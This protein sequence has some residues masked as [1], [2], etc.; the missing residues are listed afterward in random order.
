M[1]NSPQRRA[2]PVVRA[3]EPRSDAKTAPSDWSKK[4]ADAGGIPRSLRSGRRPPSSCP[5]DGMR[6]RDGRWRSPTGKTTDVEKVRVV[7]DWILCQH[8]P[9]SQGFEAAESG[10]IRDHARD[11]EISRRG[12]CGDI[13]AALRG[14]WCVR[15]ACQRATSYGIRVGPSAFRLQGPRSGQ[16]PTSARPSTAAPRSSCPTT[17][18]PRWT[19]PMSPRWRARGDE[20]VAEVEQPAGG[21]GAPEALRRMEAGNWLA[22][23]TA[24]TTWRCPTRPRAASSRSSCTRSRRRRKAGA[25]ASIRTPSSYTITTREIKAVSRAAGAVNVTVPAALLCALVVGFALG[26]GQRRLRG[27]RARRTRARFIVLER[28]RNSRRWRSTIFPGEPTRS[29]TI[30]PRSSSVNFLGDLV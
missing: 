25:T 7:Y 4:I 8:L 9:E 27:E 2:T 1:R 21:S 23:N 12:K 11:Q 13:N 24:P 18:G 16:A 5:P 15:S 17:A 20:R 29:P 19:R 26:A 28:V 14:H 30:G 3:D 22:F 10:D 6:P